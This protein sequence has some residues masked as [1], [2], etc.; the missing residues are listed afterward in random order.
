[1]PSRSQVF[2]PMVSGVTIFLI[3]AALIGSGFQDWGGAFRAYVRSFSKP[4]ADSNIYRAHA[5][6]SNCAA[7]RCVECCAGGA[8]CAQYVNGL[9]A[10]ALGSCVLTAFC[11]KGGFPSVQA[12]GLI[13]RPTAFRMLVH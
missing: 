3:G 12:Q 10:E 5:H 6:V 8:Y 1:M 4:T 7:Y 9:P 13:S 2:P 11:L